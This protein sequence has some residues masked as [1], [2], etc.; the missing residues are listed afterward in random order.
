MEVKKLESVR[1]GDLRIVLT[2]H[3]TQFFF[4]LAGFTE[5]FFVLAG[6]LFFSNVRPSR[7]KV[8]IPAQREVFFVPH[9]S[10]GCVTDRHTHRRTDIEILIVRTSITRNTQCYVKLIGTFHTFSHWYFFFV[11]GGVPPRTPPGKVLGMDVKFY[12]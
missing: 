7:R 5:Y 6:S 4:F 11:S 12:Y 10:R 1:R 8:P 2:T 3:N 9:G